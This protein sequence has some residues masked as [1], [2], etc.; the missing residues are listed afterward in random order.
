MR[1][2]GPRRVIAAAFHPA[3]CIRAVAAFAAA[4]GVST[5]SFAI[6]GDSATFDFDLP[7]TATASQSPPYPSVA[8]LMLLETA[9]GV[10]FTLT[11]TWTSP[12]AGRFGANSQIE[13]IDYAYGGSPLTDF[14]PTYPGTLSNASFRF[15][16]GAPVRSFDFSSSSN[17]GAG[18]SSEAGVITIDFFSRNN[19]PDANR[20]DAGFAN[21]V[22][23]V[24]GTT[25]TDFT[26]TTASAN[27][28]PSPVQGVLS[29]TGY[30]LEGIAPTPSNWVGGAQELAPF[31]PVGEPGLLA[32]L[33]VGLLVLG[34]TRLRSR[35]RT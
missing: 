25:L 22:W 27:A 24:L 3:R 29:V 17:L 13:R 16:S 11:P 10:Q 35:G 2:S 8:S 20:F 7:A 30:S 34:G 19:D 1:R 4:A 18:Y 14:T 26:G 32:L 6:P 31:D 9:D 15:D 23:T 12:P 33:G 28:K 5:V 21:S